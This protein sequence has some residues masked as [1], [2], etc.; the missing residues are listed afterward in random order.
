VNHQFVDRVIE[1]LVDLDLLAP[2]TPEQMDRFR[3]LLDRLL[4][5]DKLRIPAVYRTPAAAS[6]EGEE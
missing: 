2:A 5:M 1:L 3:L 6:V 4:R